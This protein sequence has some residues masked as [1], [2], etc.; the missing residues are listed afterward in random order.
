MYVGA[1][2]TVSSERSQCTSAHDIWY[3][4]LSLHMELALFKIDVALIDETVVE[5]GEERDRAVAQFMIVFKLM[6]CLFIKICDTRRP[7]STPWRSDWY[8]L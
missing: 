3:G 5:M 1:N 4:A 2:N 6:E 7:D 8:L